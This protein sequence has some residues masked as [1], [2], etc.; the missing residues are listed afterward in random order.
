MARTVVGIMGPGTNPTAQDLENARAL[1]ALCAQAGYVTLTGGSK[2]GVMDAALA[3]A[4]GAGGDTVGVLAGPDRAGASPHADVCIVTAMGSARNNINI[5]SAD[6]VVAC[7]MEP[8]TLSEIA[9]A[10]KAGKEVVMLTQ[11]A[12]AKAFLSELRPALVR[13][14]DTPEG[15]FEAVRNIILGGSV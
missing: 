13:V 12:Q 5:L 4:K 1:G 6:A 15:A 7:G 9:M 11:N 10:L 3:G 8:G 14:A 2:Q